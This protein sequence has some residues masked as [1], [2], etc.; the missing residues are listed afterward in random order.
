[1]GER[2]IDLDAEVRKLSEKY[3]AGDFQR[4]R[5]KLA[6]WI[7]G[8]GGGT[9][10]VLTIALAISIALGRYDPAYLVILTTYGGLTAGVSGTVVAFYFAGE[11]SR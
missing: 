4:F 9:F 1:M 5:Q 8:I 10:S 7:V 3:G 11:E 6:L 2:Q